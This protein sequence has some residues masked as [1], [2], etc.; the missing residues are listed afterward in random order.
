M[1]ATL[2]KRGSMFDAIL[3]LVMFVGAIIASLVTVTIISE[4]FEEPSVQTLLNA[5]AT[6]NNTREV[7][8]KFTTGGTIDGM[9]VTIFF[10]SH[11][12]II[13]LAAIVPISPVFIIVNLIFYGINLVLAYIFQTLG[14]SLFDGFGTAYFF[15]HS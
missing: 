8:E 10:L 7:A 14:T 12:V 15:C 2:N 6:G 13:V 5:S 3:I 9:V 1:I 11:I 4:F